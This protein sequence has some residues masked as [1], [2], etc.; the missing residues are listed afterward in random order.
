MVWTHW[1]V[2]WTCYY[3]EFVMK[4][5]TLALLSAMTLI[6]MCHPVA[7]QE[8]S[9]DDQLFEE[10]GD[11]LFSDLAPL[12]PQREETGNDELDRQLQEELGGD[13]L[14][15][16]KLMSP[17][18]DVADAM[19]RVQDRL[20]RRKLTAETRQMQQGI[21]SSF[22]KLIAQLQKQQQKPPGGGGQQQQQQRKK[23][24]QQGT[25]ARQPKPIPGKGKPGGKPSPNPAEAP[26]QRGNV[27]E[28]TS[29]AASRDRM[30]DE[31]W[32][33]LPASARQQLQSARP[34]KFLPRYERLI[35]DYF[36]RLSDERLP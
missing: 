27:E 8:K 6:C 11:D 18:Q 2:S 1:I 16:K 10:L 29:D 32:G 7:A 22:D 25:K 31:A 15:A 35:E 12:K 17:L 26:S 33:H 5:H 23:Q 30:M 14:P 28:A 24:Q 20:S 21:V 13:P 34:E 3:S 4:K 36:K 19:V 9:L